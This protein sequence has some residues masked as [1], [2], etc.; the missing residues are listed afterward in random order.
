MMLFGF[1]MV[2]M[3]LFWVAIIVGAVWLVMAVARGGQGRSWSQTLPPGASAGETPLDIL[4]ARYAK[5]EITKDQFDQM[6]RDLGD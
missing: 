4:K 5:G 6:R 3:V 1:G 2:M